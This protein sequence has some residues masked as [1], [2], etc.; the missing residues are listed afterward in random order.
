MAQR[1]SICLED[2]CDL[3]DPN[4]FAAACGHQALFHAQCLKPWILE[5]GK[6]KYPMCPVC[7][8]PMRILSGELA[9]EA[10][11]AAADTGIERRVIPTTEGSRRMEAFRVQVCVAVHIFLLVALHVAG[12][13]FH[14]YGACFD[15]A[16]V[17]AVL[18]FCQ[19]GWVLS[20]ISWPN[21]PGVQIVGK[22][23]ALTAACVL[24][25]I[26][27]LEC[28]DSSAMGACVDIV[29]CTLACSLMGVAYCYVRD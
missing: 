13:L 10:N 5:C 23:T 26:L 21:R 24:A 22:I 19:A 1:C 8:G 14:A 20:A 3:E 17:G 25:R 18:S 11:P 16:C 27:H 2:V 9:Q 12:A 4:E 6:Q 15:V 7:R 29:C 28:G